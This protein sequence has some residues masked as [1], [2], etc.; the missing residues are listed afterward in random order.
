MICTEN[1]GKGFSQR[2]AHG[3]YILYELRPRCIY[4]NRELATYV[5]RAKGSR[6]E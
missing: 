4:I 1:E 3:I 2:A 6:I 5:S